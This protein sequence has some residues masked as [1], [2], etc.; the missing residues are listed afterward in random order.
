MRV[1]VVMVIAASAVGAAWSEPVQN[2]AVVV[3]D[4]KWSV[5][6]RVAQDN[7]E[8]LEAGMAL[9]MAS[10]LAS[11]RIM[12][13]AC[14]QRPGPGERLSAQ[15]KGLSVVGSRRT[16][17][18]AEVELTAPVQPLDC[19]IEKSSIDTTAPTAREFEQSA[20]PAA[21]TTP[22]LTPAPATPPVVREVRTEY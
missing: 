5:T 12:E 20:V 22:V 10:T 11:R 8:R 3:K 13:F 17:E 18:W 19:K 1:S 21:D 2:G 7:H 6:V 14:R 16:P 15:L 4:G 9:R